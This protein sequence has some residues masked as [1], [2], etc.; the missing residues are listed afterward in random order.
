[1]KKHHK[2]VLLA[3]SKL[4]RIKGLISQALI[5]WNINHDELFLI[6]VL[7][8]FYDMKEGIKNNHNK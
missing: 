7:K 4:N 2:I 6:N 5:D 3:K 8:E 1:M